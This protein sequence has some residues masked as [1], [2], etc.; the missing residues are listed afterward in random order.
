ME[1]GN[2]IFSRVRMIVWVNFGSRGIEAWTGFSVK[3]NNQV[4]ES[5]QQVP[6]TE[7]R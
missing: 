4:A 1:F 2:E 5:S 3:R 6:N 7:F